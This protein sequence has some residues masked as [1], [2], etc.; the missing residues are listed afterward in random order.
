MRRID[1]IRGLRDELKDGVKAGLF[2]PLLP[3]H[4]IYLSA[5]GCDGGAS[6]ACS[7]RPGTVF[8]SGRGGGC[9]VTG[10]RLL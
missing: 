3:R 9:L 5:A 4:D 7:G 10:G 1:E 8:P 6:P 2:W